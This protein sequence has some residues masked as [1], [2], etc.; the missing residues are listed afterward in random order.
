MYGTTYSLTGRI[1]VVVVTTLVV[2]F[3]IW[4]LVPPED[5]SEDSNQANPDREDG[6]RAVAT[7]RYLEEKFKARDTYPSR[8]VLPP[9]F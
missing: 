1:V 5:H 4:Q 8:L 6:A 3:A 9:P 2:V 7:Q